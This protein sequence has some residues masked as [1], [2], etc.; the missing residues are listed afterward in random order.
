MDMWEVA[1]LRNFQTTDIAKVG[2]ADRKMLLAEW[3]LVCKQPLAN[4]K[5]HG[6]A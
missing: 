6:V 3:S 2:D 1:Y 5:A 4:S